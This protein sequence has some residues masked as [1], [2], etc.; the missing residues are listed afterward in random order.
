MN[1]VTDAILGLILGLAVGVALL[2]ILGVALR[3]LWNTTP[4]EIAGVKRIT[5]AQ[6]IMPIFLPAIPFGG[7]RVVTVGT[8]APVGTAAPTPPS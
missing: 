7:R 3:W 5:V 1:D 8:P 6:A 4:P 2:A